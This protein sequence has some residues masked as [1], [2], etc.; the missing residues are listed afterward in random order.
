MINKKTKKNTNER[1]KNIIII[2]FISITFILIV[3]K[4]LKEEIAN[5]IAEVNRQV[6]ARISTYIDNNM[7]KLDN[8]NAYIEYNKNKY[9]DQYDEKSLLETFNKS[10]APNSLEE[11]AIV[12]KDGY[13]NYGYDKVYVGDKKFFKESIKGKSYISKPIKGII[14]EKNHIVYSKPIVIN[15]K[16]DGVLV[17]L[18]NYKGVALTLKQN[19][20]SD[21]GSLYVV[22]KSGNILIGDDKN[23]KAVK[24]LYINSRYL[25]DKESKMK[26]S[27][28]KHAKEGSFNNGRIYFC[29][30]LIEGTDG[31]YLV[32][33]VPINKVFN[34]LN[35]IIRISLITIV[36]VIVLYIANSYMKYIKNEKALTEA[37]YIDSLTNI[38]NRKKFKIDC[39]EKLRNSKSD[40]RYI[41]ITIDVNKLKFINEVFGYKEGDNVIKSIGSNLTTLNYD[42]I[43]GRISDDTFGLMFKLEKCIDLETKLT[44]LYDHIKIVCSSK[45]E[46]NIKLNMGVYLIQ[47]SKE[48]IDKIID[49]ANIARI[50]SKKIKEDK[51]YIYDESLKNKIDQEITIES[52][53]KSGLESGEFKVVYQPKVDIHTEQIVG[54]ES[55]IRW[56]HNR[57][58]F[59][60]PEVF[61]PIAERNG[62]IDLIGKWVLESVCKDI[63][64]CKLNGEKVVPISINLSRVELYNVDLIPHIKNT[65]KKYDI[66][67][68]LIEIEITET[69]ALNDVEYINNRIHQIKELGIKVSMDDFGTGTSTLSNLKLIDIDILKIDR[70]MVLDLEND[71]KTYYIIKTII[72][73]AKKFNFKVVCEGVESTKQVEM[74]R[75]I[76]CDMIQGYVFFK[77]LNL[78]DFRKVLNKQ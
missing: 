5:N 13:I 27:D 6:K 69:A 9:G 58:G 17:G 70:T 53:L 34:S 14:G 55:L 56:I 45:S 28:C 49:N 36:L 11:V 62:D 60:S 30:N 74:L 51:Y 29:Y 75:E 54:A 66:E 68:E 21:K 2:G 59:I 73:L 61:I 7:S 38:R 77:P 43:H 72:R 50:E 44:N 1:I 12:S 24:E 52:D 42:N 31:W 19:I 23:Q 67:P 15:N 25:E 18:S 3:D 64:E 20:Y 33:I 57:K 41:L 16:I 39:E 37:I 78:L 40:E 10:K 65:I 35:N 8:I 22:D 32:S 63:R 47:D 26:R 71:K 48:E 4:N 46:L 76:N